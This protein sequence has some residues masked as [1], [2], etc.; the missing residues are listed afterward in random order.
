[1]TPPSIA[2]DEL[3]CH[4]KEGV[5]PLFNAIIAHCHVHWDRDQQTDQAKGEEEVAKHSSETQKY[6]RIQANSVHQILLFCPQNGF[7]P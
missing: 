5:T 6:C 4:Q 1:M 2:E 3:R 7:H